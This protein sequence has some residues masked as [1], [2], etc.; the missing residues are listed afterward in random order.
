MRRDLA[1]YVLPLVLALGPTLVSRVCLAGT[2]DDD[3]LGGIGDT[4][5]STPK[6]PDTLPAPGASKAASKAASKD[7]S[8]DA[9]K[10]AEKANKASET[11]L[12]RG[13]MTPVEPYST[14]VIDR[15]KAVPRKALLKR[16]RFEVTPSAGFSLNDPYYEH[17]TVS[18]SAVFYPHDAFGFGIGADYLYA[19]A[20]NG[21]VD[22]VRAGLT[23]VLG[24]FT[25]P[26]LFVHADMY[27]LPIYGKVSVF[28]SAIVHFDLYASAGAGVATAFASRMPPEV[29]IAIGQH[30]VVQDWLAFRFE[31]RDH[32]FLDQQKSNQ[33]FR[34]SVQSYVLFL[35]GLSFFIPPTFDYTVQ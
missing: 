27:W 11:G 17:F 28:D 5:V 20:R 13:P 26:R 30:Y 6:K 15:V 35:A 24:Q 9:S 1:W 29:N 23:S 33:H 19:H 7:V 8:K 3:I 16:H 21:N 10:P 2:K 25:L 12:D 18:G 31:V 4:P 32:L 22:A 34:S 14:G